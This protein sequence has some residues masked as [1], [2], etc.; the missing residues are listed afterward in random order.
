MSDFLHTNLHCLAFVARHH[1]VDLSPERLQHDYAVG[2]DPV[3]VRRLL[4]MARD[5]GLRARHLSL[6]WQSLFRLGEA[7]PVLAELTNG[8]WVVVAGAGGS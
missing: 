8:N 7:F 6:D 1:G 3:A 4:R 5:A 2:N